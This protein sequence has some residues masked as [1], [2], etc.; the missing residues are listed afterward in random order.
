MQNKIVPGPFVNEM[1][2][3]YLGIPKDHYSTKVDAALNLLAMFTNETPCSFTINFQKQLNF[4]SCQVTLNRSNND[5]KAE[6]GYLPM[7]IC[8]L[9]INSWSKPLKFYSFECLKKKYERYKAIQNMIDEE[10]YIDELL[11]EESELDFHPDIPEL[12]EKF[13]DEQIEALVEY[14]NAK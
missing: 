6:S 5:Y 4:Q 9:F 10:G 14:E 3:K 7:T 11:E 13:S 1:I 12:F 2:S 8:L